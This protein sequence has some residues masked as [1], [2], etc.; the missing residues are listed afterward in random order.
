VLELS[1]VVAQGA[2]GLLMGWALVSPGNR[3]RADAL[4]LAAR[5]AF[6]LLLGLAPLLV[7]AGTIEGNISPSGAPFPLKLSIGLVTGTLFY[8]YLIF[9]G[10]PRPLK[11]GALT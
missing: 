10:R 4:V 9:T 6:T 2:G 8:S 7:V 1:I 3:T 11:Q 5:R